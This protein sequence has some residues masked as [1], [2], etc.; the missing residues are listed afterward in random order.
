MDEK[1]KEENSPQPSIQA[2]AESGASLEKIREILFGAQA[3]EVDTRFARLEELITAQ[4]TSVRDEMNHRLEALEAYVRNEVETLEQRSKNETQK[5]KTQREEIEAEL[6][7]AARGLDERVT[8]LD[9]QLGKTTQK[10]RDTLLE[11]S[12]NLRDELKQTEG[13][14][15]TTVRQDL[16]AMQSA[17]V[18][19][20]QLAVMLTEMVMRLNEQPSS[21]GAASHAAPPP[22]GS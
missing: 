4:I 19:R 17:K 22:N 13:N 8:E 11:N 10:M 1:S 15:T 14:L 7:Q 6:K 3:R 21:N 12:K 9:E 20:N 16:D 2:V 5:R 18:D